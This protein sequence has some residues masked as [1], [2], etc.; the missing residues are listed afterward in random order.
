MC[1]GGEAEL[2]K[3][4]D[5]MTSEVERLTNKQV[6]EK[7]ERAK[8]LSDLDAHKADMADT[9]KTLYEAE[10]IRMKDSKKFQDDELMNKFA[11]DA[12]TQAL[13]LFEK[14]GSAASFVQAPGPEY[15]NFRRIIEVS[16]FITPTNKEKVLE[17]LDQGSEAAPPPGVAA[18][19]SSG[20][21]QILGVLKG[22]K[23]EMIQNG[24]DMVN[25]EHQENEDFKEIKKVKLEHLGVLDE[26]I[27]DKG[28]RVGDLRLS[29]A[30]DHDALLDSETEL[31]NSK[32]YL[33]NLDEECAS[34]KK[35]RDMRLKM[36]T[37][38]IAAVGEAIAILNEDSARDVQNAAFKSAAAAFISKAAS[39]P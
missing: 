30:Q 7:A 13:R 34:K 20:V 10:E 19:M 22:M 26:T 27:V 24:K 3:V 36:K 1:D 21:A 14:E 28:K 15:K 17:F 25:E 38:E 11:I 35:M 32:N 33:A 29:I 18:E 23:D 16:R 6:E 2:K 31:L 37:D 8:L 4:I 39:K 9:K 5:H 12:I